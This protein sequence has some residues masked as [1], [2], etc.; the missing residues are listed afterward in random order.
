MEADG[1]TGPLFPANTPLD[2][3]SQKRIVDKPASDGPVGLLPIGNEVGAAEEI[4]WK[5][6]NYIRRHEDP[7]QKHNRPAG[8]ED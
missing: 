5:T 8:E 2:G 1:G 6:M 4:E 7:I 3:Q